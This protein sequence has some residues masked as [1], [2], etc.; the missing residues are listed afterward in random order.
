[1]IGY[2]RVN[3][4]VYIYIHVDESLDGE[5]VLDSS[6]LPCSVDQC[7]SPDERYEELVVRSDNVLED[8]LFVGQHESCRRDSRTDSGHW[9]N[10]RKINET[11]QEKT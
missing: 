2:T 8:L 3:V 11:K 4:N 7:R 6:L 1:M 9:R 10:N 5:V